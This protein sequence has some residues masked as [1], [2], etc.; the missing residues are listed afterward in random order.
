MTEIGHDDWT[1]LEFE[2][3]MSSWNCWLIHWVFSQSTAVSLLLFICQKHIPINYE[4]SLMALEK[5]SQQIELSFL[6]IPQLTRIV[7]TDEIYFFLIINGGK[8]HLYH[9]FQFD[10]CIWLCTTLL[11]LV[12]NSKNILQY[13]NI[14]N[15]EWESIEMNTYLD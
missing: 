14:Y 12:L 10:F 7:H 3:L 13:N 5:K 11:N 4:L 15:G 9:R 1:G 2:Y 6:H 8:Y